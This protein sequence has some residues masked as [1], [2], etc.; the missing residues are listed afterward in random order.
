MAQKGLQTSPVGCKG[1]LGFA[2][3]TVDHQAQF[4]RSN[5]LEKTLEAGCLEQL[6]TLLDS[7]ADNLQV[8]LCIFHFWVTSWTSGSHFFWT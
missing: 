2:Q 7:M 8:N 3:E 4:L 6:L 5:A 1:D